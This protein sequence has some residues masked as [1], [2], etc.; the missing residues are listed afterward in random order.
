MNI[1][2]I[3][4]G[5]IFFIFAA[6]IEL[7]DMKKNIA[8]SRLFIGLLLTFL[9]YAAAMIVSY[10]WHLDSTIFAT[11]VPTHITMLA[12][13]IILI[14]I[15]KKQINYRIAMPKFKETLKP[16]ALSLLCTVVINVVLNLITIITGGA[17][18]VQKHPLIENTNVLQVF[19]SVF[20]L[21]SISEELLFRG[22]LQNYL[23]PLSDKGITLFKTRISLPVF[24]SAL[25]FSLAHLI[26][27]TSGVNTMFIVRILV[28]TF[29]LGLLAGYYQEKHDNNIFAILV[30]M[31]GNLPGLIAACFL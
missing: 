26:L 5:T 24:I 15:F 6:L 12:L 8:I 21:A 13:S 28:F 3:V 10:Y 31:A 9:V 20:I 22:F 1:K 16:V 23:R 2:I 25:A 11:S 27:L 17:A 19:L 14:L 18:A 4:R 7:L 29:V 30:H